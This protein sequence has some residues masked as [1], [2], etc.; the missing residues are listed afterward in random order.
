M[1][2]NGEQEEDRVLRF[3]GFDRLGTPCPDHWKTLRRRM[4]EGSAEGVERKRREA[5][6]KK[7]KDRELLLSMSSLEE[8]EYDRGSRIVGCTGV[9][10]NSFRGNRKTEK[11]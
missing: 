11:T 9:E 8:L 4:K 3:F 6:S 10:E 5:R 7:K 2:V 1:I